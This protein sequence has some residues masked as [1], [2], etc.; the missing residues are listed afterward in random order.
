MEQRSLKEIQTM[1]ETNSL[2]PALRQLE[3]QRCGRRLSA[4]RLVAL[5]SNAKKQHPGTAVTISQAGMPSRLLCGTA[6]WR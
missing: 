4:L 6:T 1:L 5:Q 3:K 2:S